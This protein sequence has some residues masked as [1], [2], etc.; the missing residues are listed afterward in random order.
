[1]Q[2]MIDARAASQKAVDLLLQK[3]QNKKFKVHT[4]RQFLHRAKSSRLTK[5]EKGLICDQAIIILE[6]FYAHLPFKRALYAVDPVQRLKLIRSA[7][8]EDASPEPDD[9]SFHAG[10]TGAFTSLRDVHTVYCLPKPFAGTVAFLPFFVDYYLA[11]N[12]E[13]RF[14]VTRMLEGFDP[15]PGYFCRFSEITAWNGVAIGKAVDQLAQAIP[16]GNQATRTLRGTMRLS[17]R[18]LTTT[19]P[20]MEDVVYVQYKPYLTEP[21]ASGMGKPRD[22][23]ERVIA[24]PWYVGE[25]LNFETLD[26]VAGDTK[27]G[28]TPS[29]SCIQ[30]SDFVNLRKLISTQGKG[31]AS[32]PPPETRLGF[33]E[34]SFP[35]VFEVHHTGEPDWA[36]VLTAPKYPHKK[37]GYLRIRRFP[38]SFEASVN[39]FESILHWFNEQEL[40]P[41]GLLLDI[42]SNPGG[43]IAEAESM[44]QL[45]SSKPIKPARFHYPN[46]GA[47]QSILSAISSPDRI[48]ATMSKLPAN[49]GACV[50]TAAE[51]FEAWVDGVLDGAGS[52]SAVTDG[53]PITI[54]EK[55]NERGQVYQGPIVLLTDACT[56]SAADIFSGGFQDHRIGIVIGM[57]KN[58]GGGGASSWRHAK[59]LLRLKPLTGLAIKRLPKHAAF[60]LAIQR[61]AR[62]KEYYGHPVEDIGVKSDIH[63][64]RTFED[65]LHDSKYLMRFACGVLAEQPV[66]KLKIV[67]KL[68][69]TEEG[70]NVTVRA[71]GNYAK[72]VFQLDDHPALVVPMKPADAKNSLDEAP[73]IERTFSIPIDYYDEGHHRP[74]HVEVQGF[75]WR[76]T[77]KGRN[78]EPV[79]RIRKPLKYPKKLIAKTASR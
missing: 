38:D 9:L 44:L 43:N 70:V 69:F 27:T 61:S 48:D 34:L 7:V 68:E 46:T 73:L 30:V 75:V 66:Y 51:L 67:D 32:P 53:R 11:K 78:L 42:H 33:P 36:H 5:E 52:G 12:G 59:E 31:K 64:K 25:G 50:S 72:L 77:L 58:T 79:A 65:I 54:G 6:Q 18:Q 41:D 56:Y 20:P 17:A 57:D 23:E 39:D 49:Q 55:A 15:D 60:G 1:M 4:L 71:S 63:Y 35:E 47:I 16:G 76:R 19:S 45:L 24:V 10:V 74:K 13:R 37:F 62:V 3:L 21:D 8:V 2:T 22:V 28:S 40:A 29:A 14:V 26:H